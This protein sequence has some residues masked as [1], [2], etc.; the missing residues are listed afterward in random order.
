MDSAWAAVRAL[1]SGGVLMLENLRRDR[2]EIMNDK[3]FAQA[4]SELGDVFVEDSF[5]VCHRAHASVVSLPTLLS[6][7]AGLLVEE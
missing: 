7:Y 2:G 1:P 5:D 4:L 3:K 6:S